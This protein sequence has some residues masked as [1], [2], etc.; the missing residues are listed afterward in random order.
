MQL[1][2]RVAAD[3]RHR[4]SVLLSIELIAE[5][6]FDQWSM[7]HIEGPMKIADVKAPLLAMRRLDGG[8]QQVAMLLRSFLDRLRSGNGQPQSEATQDV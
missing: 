6:M 3:E 1:Y 8:G 4:D 2:A 5:R 7:G